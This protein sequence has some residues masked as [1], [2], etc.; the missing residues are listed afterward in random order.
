[1]LLPWRPHL[2][3]AHVSCVLDT[4]S[5]RRVCV[6]AC[7]KLNLNIIVGCDC[8]CDNHSYF[9]ALP[10]SN[11]KHKVTREP[12]NRVGSFKSDGKQKGTVRVCACVSAYVCV[13]VCF[14]VCVVASVL[15][16]SGLLVGNSDWLMGPE[17]HSSPVGGCWGKLDSRLRRFVWN[18][19]L[20][21]VFFSLRSISPSSSS[22][23][24]PSSLRNGKRMSE[25]RRGV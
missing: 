25:S 4:N 2:H 15:A 8:Y 6:F 18:L 14:L 12:T 1:M 16:A 20:E 17:P 23:P 19:L 10:P 21:S 24:L 11:Q 13:C 3:S 5:V 7:Q 9:F 22:T